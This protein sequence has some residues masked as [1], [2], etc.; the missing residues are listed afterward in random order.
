MSDACTVP[1]PMP[2]T[3]VTIMPSR[4]IPDGPSRR[5]DAAG[6]GREPACRRQRRIYCRLRCGPLQ[7][8]PGPEKRRRR[9]QLP[10][11]KKPGADGCSMT[12]K[13]QAC[14][15]ARGNRTEPSAGHWDVPPRRWATGE[16][17]WGCRPII[18][19]ECRNGNHKDTRRKKKSS[20]LQA[21]AFGTVI[22][23]QGLFASA[24]A[25]C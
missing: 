19:R 6:F 12:G 14:C 25:V 18:S 23:P 24:L 13:R 9:A 8:L 11:Q 20:R 17:G 10:L 4:G 3:S 5:Q 15:T 22:L 1:G 2:D 16:N 7:K 21:A